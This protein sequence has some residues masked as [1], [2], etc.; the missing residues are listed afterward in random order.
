[1]VTETSVEFS[2]DK[3]GVTM[4]TG[5]AAPNYSAGLTKAQVLKSRNST[6]WNVVRSLFFGAFVVGMLAMM[7][8][9][10]YIVMKSPRCPEPIK[11]A[12]PKTEAN[13]SL[14][15][16]SN[17]T[18]E[19]GSGDTGGQPIVNETSNTNTTGEGSDVARVN[20]GELVTESTSAALTSMAANST[21]SS[22]F[23]FE[24]AEAETVNT[25]VE[26]LTTTIAASPIMDSGET[27]EGSSSTAPQLAI[28]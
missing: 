13:S 9:S 18:T 8:G 26:Q 27:I 3:S 19:S 6:G 10:I 5:Q 22:G 2:A 25:I 28:V 21:S 11:F 4:K 20:Y 1:M 17:D 24:T 12:N 16:T 15:S 23:R 14:N 7:F